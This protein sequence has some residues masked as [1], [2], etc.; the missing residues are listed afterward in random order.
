MTTAEVEAL[1]RNM[2]V[3]F[4]LPFTVLSVVG[5]PIGWNVKISASGTAR[6]VSFDVAGVRPAAIRAAV[7]QKLE[8][9]LSR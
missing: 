1:V 3:H 2:I 9:E 5:S 4:G 8:A 6:V 7:Q